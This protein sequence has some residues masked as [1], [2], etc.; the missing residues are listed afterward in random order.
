MAFNNPVDPCGWSEVFMITVL[1][2]QCEV[3]CTSARADGDDLWL[4]AHELEAATGWSMKPEGLC[5]GDACLPIPRASA[6]DYVKGDMLNA[7]ACWRRL[8]HPIAHD[9]A[10]ELWVLG[11]SANDRASALKSLEAP[12]FALPDLAGTTRTLSEQR[13]KKVLL[14]TW[15]SW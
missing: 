14:A 10:G 15:A 4:S 6:G 3:V 9:G 12:D 1:H 13:G 11:T 7:T 5:R 8:Q 2:E